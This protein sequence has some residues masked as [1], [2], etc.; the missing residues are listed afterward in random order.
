LTSQTGEQAL[1]HGATLEKLEKMEFELQNNANSVELALPSVLMWSI[2]DNSIVGLIPVFCFSTNVMFLSMDWGTLLTSS[3]YKSSTSVPIGG[4]TRKFSI[5]IWRYIS[6]VYNVSFLFGNFLY[7]SQIGPMSI[8]EEKPEKYIPLR[9]VWSGC[10]LPLNWLLWYFMHR[11]YEIF[12]PIMSKKQSILWGSSGALIKSGGVSVI[13]L[14]CITLGKNFIAWKK[15]VSKAIESH[16]YEWLFMTVFELGFGMCF[17]SMFIPLL[18]KFQFGFF[19]ISWFYLIKSCLSVE[20][21]KRF[22]YSKQVA[23]SRTLSQLM[24][25][26]NVM[27]DSI[28]YTFGRGILFGFSP[29]SL[30]VTLL[31]DISYELWHFG[32][33]QEEIAVIFTMKLFHPDRAKE[34]PK[35]WTTIC[36]CLRVFSK[37][38]GIPKI[39]STTYRLHFNLDDHFY[40]IKDTSEVFEKSLPLRVIF[41]NT[42]IELHGFTSHDW[43]YLMDHGKNYSDNMIELDRQ[44]LEQNNTSVDYIAQ[45]LSQYQISKMGSELDDRLEVENFTSVLT[46]KSVTKSHSNRPFGNW[47]DTLP[48]CSEEIEVFQSFLNVYRGHIFLRYQARVIAKLVVSLTMVF[49]YFLCQLTPTR[50]LPGFPAEIDSL[51]GVY[52]TMFVL[53]DLSEYYFITFKLHLRRKSDR[54]RNLIYLHDLFFRGFSMLDYRGQCKV[55][56]NSDPL[57]MLLPQSFWYLFLRGRQTE[58]VSNS[59]V[60]EKVSAV[61][62]SLSMTTVA[63]HLSFFNVCVKVYSAP[64]FLLLVA[65]VVFFSMTQSSFTKSAYSLPLLQNSTGIES[66]TWDVIYDLCPVT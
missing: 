65:I 40:D 34:I 50:F 64:F 62:E 46:K 3:A 27:L 12:G 28:R 33:R 38:S 5:S 35:H 44:K 4:S 54:K 66:L 31:K 60:S 18:H 11:R 7:Y 37:M 13:L 26:G 30:V 17:F 15:S 57:T 47:L 61:N 9:G 21:E 1:A 19:R 48:V 55:P 49:G 63:P 24:F 22:D 45:D 52:V 10:C 32:L 53:V 41:A 39:W 2:M 56:G 6:Q 23:V 43:R 51:Y 25:V 14:A 29:L 59:A 20:D 36:N 58:T 42:E 8:G 16:P